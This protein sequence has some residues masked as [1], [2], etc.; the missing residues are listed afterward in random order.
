MLKENK[1]EEVK[2][3]LNQRSIVERD[4]EYLKATDYVDFFKED[5][6]KIADLL[7]KA[8][9]VSTNVDF[10]QYLILQATAFRQANP[11]S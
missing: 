7:I 1:I 6:G 4:G 5:F 2:K 11:Y 9:T 10:N 8:S 3:I